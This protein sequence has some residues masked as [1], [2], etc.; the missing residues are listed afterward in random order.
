[1]SAVQAVGGGEDGAAEVARQAQ[2]VRRLLFGEEVAAE[3]FGEDR[4]QVHK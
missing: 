1:M 3:R 2:Q 4:V